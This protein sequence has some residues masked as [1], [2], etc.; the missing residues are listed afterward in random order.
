[1]EPTNCACAIGTCVYNEGVRYM[2]KT[3]QER[4]LLSESQVQ[5]AFSK[6]MNSPDVSEES[7]E[8][9]ET[10]LDE[11]PPESPL[12]HRLSTELD[13]VRAIAAK[14]AS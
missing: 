4:T 7:F 1:M 5:R 12:R 14:R 11:L 3:T 9:A 8:K 10:L 2:F 13:E 6:L